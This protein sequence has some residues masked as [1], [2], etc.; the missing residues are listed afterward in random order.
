MGVL[1]F[2]QGGVSA[3]SDFEIPRLC[4]LVVIAAQDASRYVFKG[5]IC[6]FIG[7]LINT[8]PPKG[9]CLGYVRHRGTVAQGQAPE[10]LDFDSV[11]TCI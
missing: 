2:F 10:T 4:A 9:L 11:Q 5:A 3:G 7:V 6:F 1:V 8:H